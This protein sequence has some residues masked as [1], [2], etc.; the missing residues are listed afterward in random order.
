MRSGIYFKNHFGNSFTSQ[1]ENH[2]TN[3][4]MNGFRNG[5]RNLFQN[6]FKVSLVIHSDP[7]RSGDRVE[8]TGLQ[9][10]DK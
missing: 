1:F 5:S 9:C 10:R 2:V 7:G 8:G 6:L 4:L 3:S